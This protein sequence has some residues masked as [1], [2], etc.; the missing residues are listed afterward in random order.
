M[1]LQQIRKPRPEIINKKSYPVLL[2]KAFVVQRSNTGEKIKNKTALNEH[3]FE[4]DAWL[5]P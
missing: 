3:S 5:R 4:A 1:E 2:T